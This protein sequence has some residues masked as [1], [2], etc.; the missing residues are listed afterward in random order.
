MLPLHKLFEATVTNNTL[1]TPQQILSLKKTM[2]KKTP[3]A[4]KPKTNKLNPSKEAYEVA[5]DRIETTKRDAALDSVRKML[6]Q[7]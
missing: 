4:I 7:R 2:P 5:Q 1:L 6:T 3:I